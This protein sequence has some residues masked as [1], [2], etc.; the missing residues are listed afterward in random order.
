MK[1]TFVQQRKII[2]CQEDSKSIILKIWKFIRQILG[3]LPDASCDFSQAERRIDRIPEKKDL[4][5]IVGHK[6]HH[7]SKDFFK[8]VQKSSMKPSSQNLSQSKEN[9]GS[10]KNSRGVKC[11]VYLFESNKFACLCTWIFLENIWNIYFFKRW[12]MYLI[13][14]FCPFHLPWSR[15]WQGCKKAQTLHIRIPLRSEIYTTMR[16]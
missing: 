4:L 9:K 7:V 1:R 14:S 6:S 12:K 11:K 15:Y 8:I 10:E 2:H 5:K 16:I 13:Y 3:F